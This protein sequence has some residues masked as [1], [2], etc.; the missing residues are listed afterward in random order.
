MQATRHKYLLFAVLLINF[1]IPRQTIEKI[2]I[3]HL[4]NAI[5][6]IPIGENSHGIFILFSDMGLKS[7]GVLTSFYISSLH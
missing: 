2:I 6:N 3:F 4:I 1:I 5:F 7:Y